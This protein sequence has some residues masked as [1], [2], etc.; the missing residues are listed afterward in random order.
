MRQ[1]IFLSIII[2]FLV[3]ITASVYA[4]SD[5]N[6][7]STA[8]EALDGQESEQV[9]ESQSNSSKE[10][11]EYE[12]VYGSK[13]YGLVAYILNKIR[14]FSIPVCFIALVVSLVVQNV[15]GAKSSFGPSNARDKGY[16]MIMGVITLFVI[17]QALPLI[18]ALVI[19]G[20]GVN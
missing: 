8:A 19:K 2:I 5:S 15:L 6:V 14:V 18:Y 7:N 11:K 20:W 16:K 12:E 13:S 9:T 4:T 1:K 17:A 3:F 10:L